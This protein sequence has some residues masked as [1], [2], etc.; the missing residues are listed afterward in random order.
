VGI[1]SSVKKLFVNAGIDIRRYRPL[2]FDP[3]AAQQFLLRG[4]KCRTVF[5]VGAYQG[6]V[7]AQYLRMLPEADIY[8]FEPFPQTFEALSKKFA[9]NS[10]VHLVNSA[11]TARSGEAPFY[12]N[13]MTETNSLLPRPKD[14]RR[15]FPPGGKTRR[16]INVRTISL[17]DFCSQSQ[18]RSPDVLKL[19]IQGNELEALRGAEGII[20]SG[21]VALIYTE[22][23]FVPHYESGV[24]FA[25][26]HAHLNERGFSL[27]NLYN[28]QSARFGQLRFGD[29]IFVSERLRR[30]VID[31]LP[32]EDN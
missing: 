4:L 24:L 15:Y 23:T 20:Q 12:V 18:I 2:V 11:V 6:E 22:T 8:S 21:K 29:A 27:F 10:R 32:E 31:Q 1:A 26:L 9:G 3:F 14:G 19:D 16:T 13:E 25:A 7:T 30:D 28:L 17:D 5:G